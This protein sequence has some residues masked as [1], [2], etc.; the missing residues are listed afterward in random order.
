MVRRQKTRDIASGSLSP[1]FRNNA[2]MLAAQLPA[3]AAACGTDFTSPLRAP[4]RKLRSELRQE[5]QSNCARVIIRRPEMPSKSTRVHK[6]S[7]TF[8]KW[9]QSSAAHCADL[10]GKVFECSD[11]DDADRYR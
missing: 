8:R 7:S 9:R 10:P 4:M 2:R 11:A 5:D 1:S 6:L 3:Y